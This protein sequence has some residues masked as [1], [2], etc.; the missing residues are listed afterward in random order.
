MSDT[1]IAGQSSRKLTF[2]QLP[3]EIRNA[4]YVYSLI[5]LEDGP[6]SARSGYY[7][8]GRIPVLTWNPRYTPFTSHSLQDIGDKHNHLHHLWRRDPPIW[9]LNRQIRAEVRSLHVTRYMSVDMSGADVD[10]AYHYINRGL[11]LFEQWL[12]ERVDEGLRK[13]ITRLE[14]RDYV[15]RWVPAEERRVSIYGCPRQAEKPECVIP[16]FRI[17]INEDGNS[18]VVSTPLQLDL[19]QASLLSSA[20]QDIARNAVAQGRARFDGDDIIEC[21]RYLRE[22]TE[23]PC[24]TEFGSRVQ[25]ARSRGQ[26]EAV[27]FRMQPCDRTD[28]VSRLRE[29]RYVAASI[30]IGDVENPN[31]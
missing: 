27:R 22:S 8:P 6:V 24:K 21:A 11:K 19:K 9:C 10:Y 1:L 29:F 4:I 16:A 15:Q 28:M 7:H 17:K 12:E 26:P 20:L 5:D 14:L 23:L 3:P 31:E 2:L 30:R 18:L 13:A 25:T